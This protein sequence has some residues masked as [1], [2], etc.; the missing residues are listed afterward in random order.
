MRVFQRAIM[1][2]RALGWRLDPNLIAKIARECLLKSGRIVNLRD[3]ESI[4]LASEGFA[5]PN[6][7]PVYET[8]APKRKKKRQ[9][10]A[11]AAN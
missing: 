1:R 4:L 6:G 8:I 10:H 7:Q 3:V 11:N 2:D 9:S 5:T